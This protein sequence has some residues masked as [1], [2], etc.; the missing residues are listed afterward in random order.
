MPTAVVARY[1]RR[2]H[3][4]VKR[5]KNKSGRSKRRLINKA[6]DQ[7]FAL[8]NQR[9]PL[10]TSDHSGKSTI[11]LADTPRRQGDHGPRRTQLGRGL[12]QGELAS[13]DPFRD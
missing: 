12:S 13:R 10:S 2:E 9:G 7:R 4:I 6:L 11:D 5:M 3:A 1:L 8:R